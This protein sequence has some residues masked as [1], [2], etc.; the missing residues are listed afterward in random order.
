MTLVSSR[1]FSRRLLSAHVAALPGP[2][3][4]KSWVRGHRPG[5]GRLWAKCVCHR[6]QRRSVHVEVNVS[7]RACRW[8]ASSAPFALLSLHYQAPR[9]GGIVSRSESMYDSGKL[10]DY[11]H[12]D[13]SQSRYH[14]KVNSLVSKHH[15]HSE[16]RS[17]R[18][19]SF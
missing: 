16:Y 6:S 4:E 7:T 15:N 10:K 18:A 14:D 9:S 2:A 17:T 1:R 8:I 11:H 5:L 19:T 13:T 3:Q 12:R